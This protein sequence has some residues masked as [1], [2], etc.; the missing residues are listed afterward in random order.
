MRVERGR[1]PTRRDLPP[2]ADGRRVEKCDS[3]RGWSRVVHVGPIGVGMTDVLEFGECMAFHSRVKAMLRWIAKG[4]AN[5]AAESARAAAHTA[6]RALR[7][8]YEQ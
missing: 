1:N 7:R 4:E 8:G 5:K 2:K 3:T 6:N